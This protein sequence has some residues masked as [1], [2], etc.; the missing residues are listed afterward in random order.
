[1]GEIIYENYF[2]GGHWKDEYIPKLIKTMNY[3]DWS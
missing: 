2:R 1:M 3:L